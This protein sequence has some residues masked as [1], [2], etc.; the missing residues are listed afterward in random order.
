MPVKTIFDML[1]KS[2]AEARAFVTVVENAKTLIE[3]GYRIIGCQLDRAAYLVYKP[4]SAINADYFVTYDAAR[5]DFR[6]TCPWNTQK[7]LPCKHLLRTHV[8][9]TTIDAAAEA[10]RREFEA[11]CEE[12]ANPDDDRFAEY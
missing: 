11:F 7:G 5:H 3:D 8:D 2:P 9:K 6:C 10:G 4:G 12:M 1:P